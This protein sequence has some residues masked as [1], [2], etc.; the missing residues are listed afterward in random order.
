MTRKLSREEQGILLQTARTT[1]EQ[2]LKRQDLPVLKLGD[3]P[4][5]LQEPGACFVTLTKSGELR[6][7][8]GSI[9]ASQP[10]ILD[11]RDRAISAAFEDPRFPPLSEKELGEVQIEISILTKPEKLP[12]NSP[13]ELPGL[14]RPG[15]DGVILKHHYRRATFLPQVWEKLPQPELFLDRL[16]QKMG[17]PQDTWRQAHLEVEIYQVEEFSEEDLKS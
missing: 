1:I 10:L 3:F 8:V 17:L 2:A 7:C 12:I 14:L 15:I 16:C 4:P 9:E 11:V 6:G 5:S 13:A